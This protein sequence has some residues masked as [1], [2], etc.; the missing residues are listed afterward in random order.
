MV[1]SRRALNRFLIGHIFK[2]G[3]NIQKIP[4]VGCRSSV[5]TYRR[6]HL[7]SYRRWN[8]KCRI[9]PNL[10]Y[11]MFLWFVFIFTNRTSIITNSH[12]LISGFV[13]ISSIKDSNVSYTY[14]IV[15]KTTIINYILVGEMLLMI[16]AEVLAPPLQ[17]SWYA[18]GPNVEENLR[19]PGFE[20]ISWTPPVGE[21]FFRITQG[22][23]CIN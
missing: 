23:S 17:N 1:P 8:F 7:T 9:I 21:P 16:G 5:R 18:A 22:R 2:K 3:F 12:L 6:W 20:V 10:K 13:R 11:I 15:N 14:T 19:G 4:L